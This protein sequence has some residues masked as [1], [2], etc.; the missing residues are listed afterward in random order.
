MMQQHG[1]WQITARREVYRNERLTLR[2]DDVIKPDGK[3]SKYATVR[4]Q[5]GVEVLACTS[6]QEVYLLRQ[7]RYGLG[8]QSVEAVGGTLD[9][10]ESP[11]AA[12]KRELR[13]ELG[14]TARE[15]VDLG[16]VHHTTSL[17]AHT[18]TLFMAHDLSFGKTERES[19]EDIKPMPMPLREA[20]AQALQGEIDQASTCTLL[21]R[22][23][24]YWA[25]RE[26]QREESATAT[27]K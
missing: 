3:R 17:V 15:W 12:A 26:T 16:R 1:P 8:R 25:N 18:T 13:E 5:D 10:D 22:V 20:V 2:E 24:H 11:L 4:F 6:S 19:T 21:L 27:S 23:Q 9:K 14:I 7:Y